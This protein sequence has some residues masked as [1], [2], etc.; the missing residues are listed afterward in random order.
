MFNSIMSKNYAIIYYIYEEEFRYGVILIDDNYNNAL[1]RA[2]YELL[3]SFKSY[4]ISVIESN[5]LNYLENMEIAYD[6]PSYYA[7][8]TQKAIEE[9]NITQIIKDLKYE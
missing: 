4:Y 7:G 5:D 3:N 6:D 8:E 2:Y 9:C 1:Y